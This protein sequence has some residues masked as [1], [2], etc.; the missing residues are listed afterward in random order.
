[1]WP[2][3]PGSPAELCQLPAKHVRAL[4]C[5]GLL[6]D[7]FPKIT[8]SSV[9]GR[10]HRTSVSSGTSNLC[11]QMSAFWRN[12]ALRSVLIYPYA[13]F[14]ETSL[15]LLMAANQFCIWPDTSL[16]G[17]SNFEHHVS[18]PSFTPET[19]VNKRT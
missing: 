16:I 12:G 9:S 10:L 1:M 11:D 6:Q 15:K 18:Q 19:W 2:G 14:T 7:N 5:I 13:G 4:R 3:R 8:K 17:S